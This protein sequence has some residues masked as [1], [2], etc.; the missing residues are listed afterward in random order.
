MSA[1]LACN[2]SI[3]SAPVFF[4]CKQLSSCSDADFR[5]GHKMKKKIVAFVLMSIRNEFNLNC[6]HLPSWTGPFHWQ[7]MR[8]YLQL[9]GRSSHS[10]FS[11]RSS[12]LLGYSLPQNWHSPGSSETAFSTAKFRDAVD[13]EISTRQF[14][15]VATWSRNL[16]HRTWEKIFWFR[17]IH[18]V[19]TLQKL[20]PPNEWIWST[21]VEWRLL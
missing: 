4:G 19:G 7:P 12:D 13:L 21:T 9:V 5:G 10:F 3:T 2:A 1:S 20:R 15:H 14:G 11:C 17:C 16:H 8:W 6:A 18:K